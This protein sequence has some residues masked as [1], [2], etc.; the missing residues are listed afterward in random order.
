MSVHRFEKQHIP[1][2]IKMRL[3]GVRTFWQTDVNMISWPTGIDRMVQYLKYQLTKAT[4]RHF[5]FS[6]DVLTLKVS[7]FSECYRRANFIIEVTDVHLKTVSSGKMFTKDCGNPSQYSSEPFSRQLVGLAHYVNLSG[8]VHD[9]D[10]RDNLNR[11][12]SKEH[13]KHDGLPVVLKTWVSEIDERNNIIGNPMEK[14]F[15]WDEF[16]CTLKGTD[17]EKWVKK[18]YTDVSR[19]IC[20]NYEELKRSRNFS[21]EDEPVHKCT[22]T[23]VL[24]EE[25]VR[26][27]YGSYLD[28]VIAKLSNKLYCFHVLEIISNFIHEDVYM[29]SYYSGTPNREFCRTQDFHE[30]HIRRFKDSMK[31][32]SVSGGVLVDQLYNTKR[33]RE[34]K[35]DAILYS[36][37][38]D[39]DLEDSL[40]DSIEENEYEG[41]GSFDGGVS[42]EE[43]S[44]SNAEAAALMDVEE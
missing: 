4:F 5:S 6:T 29:C 44:S 39:S 25:T 17:A 27:I 20:P 13:L 35:D 41:E 32:L 8:D 7:N 37:L 10:L 34:D 1:T 24:Y 22:S 28:A 18:I 40:G 11:I 3:Y 43:N 9:T 30:L 42:I 31:R 15:L 19:S 2:C 14:H 16:I 12:L 23:G 26:P 38:D 33:W 21:I 36:D